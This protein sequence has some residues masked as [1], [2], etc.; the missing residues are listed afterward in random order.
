MTTNDSQGAFCHYCGNRVNEQAVFCSSC[1]KQLKV[2]QVEERLLSFG[3]WGI[4]VCFAR[5]GFFVMTQQ[6]NTTVTLT[7]EQISGSASSGKPRF[8]IPYKAITKKEHTS[9]ALFK[10]L[11]LEYQDEGKTKEVSIMG[12][13]SNYGNIQRAFDL[14]PK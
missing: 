2:Q 13:F 3:P 11:Y 7:N 8:V 14:I 10:V 1:G 12:N 6:N 5:P 9:Y 4:S